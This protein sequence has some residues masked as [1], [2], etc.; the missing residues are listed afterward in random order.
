VQEQDAMV[1]ENNGPAP[2]RM[3]ALWDQADS[4]TIVMRVNGDDIAEQIPVQLTLAEFLRNYLGL[5]GTKV[6]CGQA[7]CGA[8]TVLLDGHPVFVCHI[9]AAQADR[10][11][12]QTIEGLSNGDV[13]HPLQ[14]AFVAHDALQCGFCTP[15]M[16]MA[17]KGALDA[18]VGSD[19]SALAHAIAG[20]ICRCGAYEH[21]L[22]AALSVTS[23]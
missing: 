11:E 3:S 8:C 6:A 20:N 19:R 9:L 5:T 22:D 12:I 18:G 1:A 15:G 2:D 13:L 23:P 16:I 7:A 21:I 14:A 10:A 17:L 4:R